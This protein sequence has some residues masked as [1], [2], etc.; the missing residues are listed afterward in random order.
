MAANRKRA[1][2]RTNPAQ[3]PV[4]PVKD[5]APAASTES[6]GE[7]PAPP[8]PESQAK[9]PDTKTPTDQGGRPGLSIACK[10]GAFWRAGRKWTETA[11]TVAL[12][13]LTDEQIE[14]LMN[15]PMLVVRECRIEA[16]R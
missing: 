4:N 13:S 15:E 10:A 12:A 16:E 1:S 2:T 14:Q 7:T 3:D 9:A 11:T 5:P 6:Q 8:A